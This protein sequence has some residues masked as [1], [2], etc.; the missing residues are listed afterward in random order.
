MFL[1]D[2]LSKPKLNVLYSPFRAV[3]PD[4]A[5]RPT[6]TLKSQNSERCEN[7]RLRNNTDATSLP[8]KK[9]LR[10]FVALFF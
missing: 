1:V 6:A 7:D 9:T 10:N 2:L 4:T 3:T 8:R 5:D